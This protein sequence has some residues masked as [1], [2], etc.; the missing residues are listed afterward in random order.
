MTPTDEALT[1]VRHGLR[2]EREWLGEETP[3]QAGYEARHAKP[4]IVPM[5]WR[6]RSENA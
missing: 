6:A 3:E 2:E 5:L 4:H 1:I